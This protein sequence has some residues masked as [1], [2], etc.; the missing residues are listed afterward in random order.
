MGNRRRKLKPTELDDAD[1]PMIHLGR[2]AGRIKCATST[3]NYIWICNDD[4]CI[5]ETQ[6]GELPGK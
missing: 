4:G 1:G 3:P 5:F 6:W 2:N